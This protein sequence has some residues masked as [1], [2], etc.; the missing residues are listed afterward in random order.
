MFGRT[1]PASI[2]STPIDKCS[3]DKE[4]DRD[5]AGEPGEQAVAFGDEML[6]RNA[7]FGV[8][9]KFCFQPVEEEHFVCAFVFGHDGTA[10][11]QFE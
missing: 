6:V 2:C 9:R 4:G 5:L 1:L 11:L 8:A 3:R 7:A 10:R